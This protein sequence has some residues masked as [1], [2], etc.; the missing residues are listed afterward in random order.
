LFN[1]QP[2]YIVYFERMVAMKDLL[3][4]SNQFQICSKENHPKK[5]PDLLGKER[6]VLPVMRSTRP[7]P[8]VKTATISDQDVV[9]SQVDHQYMA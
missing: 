7:F 6:T 9:Q 4:A 5:F 1:R 8:S 2:I 3:R